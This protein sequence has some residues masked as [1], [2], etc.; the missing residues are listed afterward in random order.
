MG[1]CMLYRKKGQSIR[2]KDPDNN[3]YTIRYDG[4]NGDHLLIRLNNKETLRLHV[5]DEFYLDDDE[6]SMGIIIK[7]GKSNSG[8]NIR[9]GIDA[10]KSWDIARGEI[11]FLQK[12]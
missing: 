5:L 2:V 3:I 4:F 8:G 9:I 7:H 1:F 11:P 6:K 10:P 12:K